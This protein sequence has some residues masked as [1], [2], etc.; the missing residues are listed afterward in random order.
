MCGPGHA[1]MTPLLLLLLLQA[2]D[3][4][5]AAPPPASFA[6]LDPA[7]FEKYLS[8][9][10][11]D[12]A[13]LTDENEWAKDNIPYFETDSEDFNVA[14]Y[15]RWHMFHSHMNASGWTDKA[16]GDHKWLIT[17][18]TNVDST[19]SGSAGHHIMEARWLRDP[20]VVKDYAEYWSNGASRA[21]TYWYSWASFEAF[22]VLAPA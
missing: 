16:S 2:V 22:K 17:E 9:G 5:Q 15:F 20:K 6:I 21:Y 14:Y 19:H 10:A 4:T 1:P 3:N 8:F 12:G 11:G 7:N 18:F 13:G